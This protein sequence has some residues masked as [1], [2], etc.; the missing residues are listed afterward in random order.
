M[1]INQR[2]PKSIVPVGSLAHGLERQL[3]EKKRL[4]SISK[5]KWNAKMVH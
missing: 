1:V 4:A 5:S 2:L 3:H